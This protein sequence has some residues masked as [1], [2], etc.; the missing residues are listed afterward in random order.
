MPLAAAGDPRPRSRPSSSSKTALSLPELHPEVRHLSPCLIFPYCAL[1]SA[2]FGSP[3]LDHDGPVCSRGVRPSL[4]S[5]NARALAQG[6]PPPLLE[7]ARALSRPIAP[8]GGRDSSRSYSSSHETL[9]PPFSPLCPW[10]RGLF[11]AIE[12]AVVSCPSLPYSGDRGAT[13]ARTSL[14]SGDPTAAERNSAARSRPSPWSNPLR[15]SQIA[16]L[17][18]RIT[19]HAHTPDALARLSAPKPS[20]VWPTR[21]VRSPP[22]SLTPLTRLS[23]LARPRTRALGRRSNLSRWF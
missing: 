8:S 17:R 6:V 9:S 7:L 16:R 22:L 19:L 13:L 4:T 15:S 20:S 5:S 2:N 3:V 21:S 23:V 11:R 12:F 18:S 1:C 10:T 14:N